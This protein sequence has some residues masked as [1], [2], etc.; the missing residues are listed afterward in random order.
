MVPHIYYSH[1]C[2]WILRLHNTLGAAE[3]TSQPW[4]CLSSGEAVPPVCEHTRPEAP[5]LAGA[6]RIWKRTMG[7]VCGCMLFCSLDVPISPV[8]LLPNTT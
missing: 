1:D 8:D 4:C 3:D 7:W 6:A 2:E 5:H